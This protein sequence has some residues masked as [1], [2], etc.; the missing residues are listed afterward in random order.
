MM[1]CS[2]DIEFARIV[3]QRTH[4]L[5]FL[6]GVQAMASLMASMQAAWEQ[7][8]RVAQPTPESIAATRRALGRTAQELAPTVLSARPRLTASER[9][10]LEAKREAASLGFVN[11][12]FVG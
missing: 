6:Q 9:K 3:D 7:A 8:Q 11:G 12:R 4:Q 5:C 2:N 1:T 10:R